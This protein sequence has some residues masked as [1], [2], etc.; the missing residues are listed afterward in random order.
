MV[1]RWI[2]TG[3]VKA[4]NQFRRI[5][6]YAAMPKLI[7]ALE[8]E[9]LSQS[10]QPAGVGGSTEGIDGMERDSPTATSNSAGAIW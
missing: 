1:L 8:N 9:S 2:G 10:K 5:R 3:L 6:G 7:A 4:E